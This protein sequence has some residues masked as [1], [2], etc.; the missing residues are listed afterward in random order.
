MP[1]VGIIP[2]N[3]EKDIVGEAT[4]HNKMTAD[5]SMRFTETRKARAGVILQEMRQTMI[6]CKVQE[7]AKTVAVCATPQHSAL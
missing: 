7:R 2:Q 1:T 6:G 4:I 3:K 5:A